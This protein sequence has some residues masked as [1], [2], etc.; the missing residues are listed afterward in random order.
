MKPK[1]KVFR[2]IEDMLDAMFLGESED[3]TYQHLLQMATLNPL[4]AIISR[5][6]A[7]GD[8]GLVL[9]DVSDA[10]LDIQFSSLITRTAHVSSYS[11]YTMRDREAFIM[12]CRDTCDMTLVEKV[13]FHARESHC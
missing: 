10:T 12:S 9:I 6:A 5:P 13:S 7:N 4:I 1:S 8:L 11:R 3:I 2:L